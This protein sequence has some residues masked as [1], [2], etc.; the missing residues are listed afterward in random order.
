MQLVIA[1]LILGVF[2]I[3]I[4]TAII[5]FVKLD[6]KRKSAECQLRKAAT[7]LLEADYK[8]TKADRVAAEAKA[9]VKLKHAISDCESAVNR[10]A[11]A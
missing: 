3:F 9:K 1:A 5:K 6:A 8:K 11:D 10:L 2:I 7:E 4:G